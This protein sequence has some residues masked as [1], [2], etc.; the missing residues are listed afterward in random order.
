[1][2][3]VSLD[4]K[5]I[6][7][8]SPPV[9]VSKEDSELSVKTCGIQDV[10]KNGVHPSKENEDHSQSKLNSKTVPVTLNSVTPGQSHTFITPLKLPESTSIELRHKKKDARKIGLVDRIQ[11]KISLWVSQ[12][13]NNVDGSKVEGEKKNISKVLSSQAPESGKEENQSEKVQVTHSSC[14][15][16]SENQNDAKV[17]GEKNSDVSLNCELKSMK[18][19]LS[20][21][22]K[23]V[24]KESIT[25]MIQSLSSKQPKIILEKLVFEKESAHSQNLP[26]KEESLDEESKVSLSFQDGK[27]GNVHEMKT[28]SDDGDSESDLVLSSKVNST[29]ICE[30]ADP[31]TSTTPLSADATEPT[32]GNVSPV[33]AQSIQIKRLKASD[34]L[35]ADSGPVVDEIKGEEACSA[36]AEGVIEEKIR[37]ASK[38]ISSAEIKKDSSPK[39]DSVSA[40]V[41]PNQSSNCSTNKIDGGSMAVDEEVDADKPIENRIPNVSSQTPLKVLKSFEIRARPLSELKNP[42]RSKF[43]PIAP[44]EVS[45]TA[46]VHVNIS[47]EAQIEPD[48]CHPKGGQLHTLKSLLSKNAVT[49]RV[50]KP[51]ESV[52]SEPE[53]SIS[54]LGSAESKPVTPHSVPLTLPNTK[55]IYVPI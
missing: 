8:S 3:K 53:T 29:L 19:D 52:K 17:K 28:I 21:S 11:E 44:K 47:N 9:A 1:M 46:D 55:V 35:A 48:S 32:D 34:T 27:K 22:A 6:K 14:E 24:P 41:T 13:G 25:H 33:S 51:T 49:L 45:N 18:R 2:Q 7:I 23:T 20:T 4:E 16:S 31:V 5:V 26:V 38:I 36:P 54:T 15:D 40:S 43:V 37:K 42:S 39:L 30:A 12:G 10:R 50:G